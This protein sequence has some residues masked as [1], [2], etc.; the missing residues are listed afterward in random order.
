MVLA[1]TGC[2]IS[3]AL[4]LTADKIDLSAKTIVLRTLKQRDR[5]AHRAVPVPESTLGRARS[6]SPYQ[7]VAG[8]QTYL[9]CHECG[10]N[11]RRPCQPERFTP[12]VRYPGRIRNQK[13]PPCSKMAGTPL[14]R[15]DHNLHGCR[16]RRRTGAC[17]PY[18][19]LTN[20]FALF[21]IFW[22]VSFYHIFFFYG[23]EPV[24]GMLESIYIHH[25]EPE[26][27]I[28]VNIIKKGLYSR[29]QADT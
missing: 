8:H 15:N 17:G 1:F 14:F 10:R 2:R 6:R 29:E 13:P 22:L 7:E 24:D 23:M 5:I 19:G 27:F 4:E 3:E 20:L 18:V 16:G 26:W 21:V 28:V 11:F 12:W 25:N 9:C